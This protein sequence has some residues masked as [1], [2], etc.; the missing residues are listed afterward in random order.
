MHMQVRTSTRTG[1]GPGAMAAYEPPTAAELAGTLDHVADENLESIAAEQGEDPAVIRL[2]VGGD[3]LTGG[4]PH[5][6]VEQAART[7]ADNRHE[8][9]LR[10]TLLAALDHR[11]GALRDKLRQLGDR[12]VE[13]VLVL[14]S[15]STR[16]RTIVSIGLAEELSEAELSEFGALGFDDEGIDAG[17][18]S[19]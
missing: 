19:P 10:P 11:P 17:S 15:R 1:G 14:A 16:G 18:T 7:L 2:V 6:R 5:P 8:T 13:S 4:D 12:R 3:G 9:S